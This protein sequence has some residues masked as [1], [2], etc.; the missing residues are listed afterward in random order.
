MIAFCY[1]GVYDRLGDD[2]LTTWH[3]AFLALGETLE[4]CAAKYRGIPP[5]PPYKKGGES[6][7]RN[8][9]VP[10]IK[11]DLGGSQPLGK[12]CAKGVKEIGKREKENLAW[13]VGFTLGYSGVC[14]PGGGSSSGKV[15]F[16]KLL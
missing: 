16:C 2:G 6:G 14:K 12:K 13:T 4:E 10:L 5:S 7:I 8:P 1:Y 11:G 3:P 15:H 9:E